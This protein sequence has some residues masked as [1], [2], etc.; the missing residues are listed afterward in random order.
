MLKIF[1]KLEK[2]YK[3][4]FVLCISLFAFIVFAK[5]IFAESNALPIKLEVSIPGM[6]SQVSDFSEYMLRL[7]NYM[8]Y[9]SGILAVIM[10]SIA[11]FQWVM[12]GGNQSKIGAAKSRIVGALTGLFLVFGSYMILNTINPQLTL[13]K[14]PDVTP[15]KPVTIL[16]DRILKYLAQAEEISKLD[17]KCT[18]NGEC[19]LL[20]GYSTTCLNGKCAMKS[21]EGYPCDKY[22]TNDC[23]NKSNENPVLKCKVLKNDSNTYKCFNTSCGEKSG[24]YVED[25]DSCTAILSGGLMSTYGY[26]DYNQKFTTIDGNISKCIPCKKSKEYC[27]KNEECLNIKTNTCGGNKS[28]GNCLNG[29]FNQANYTCK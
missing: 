19:N 1:Y 13:L 15:I 12:A 21:L 20:N 5:T 14:M 3:I 10:I 7:F 25:Y 11:G 9:V 8:I 4:F 17:K 24:A 6:G 16:D 29:L 26:C 23:F 18:T 22:E 28:H 2:K 27:R